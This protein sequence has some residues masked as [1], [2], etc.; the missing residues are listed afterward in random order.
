MSDKEKALKLAKK[1]IK[2]KKHSVKIIK[3]LM[4]KFDLHLSEAA[5]IYRKARSF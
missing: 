3:T 2:E 4:D 5:T 1:L